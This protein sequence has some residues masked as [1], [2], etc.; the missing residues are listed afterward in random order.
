MSRVTD[1][2]YYKTVRSS[3]S[4][5]KLRVVVFHSSSLWRR[6][7]ITFFVH[8]RIN[9]ILKSGCG[10]VVCILLMFLLF[11][12]TSRIKRWSLPLFFPHTTVPGNFPTHHIRISDI[13][14]LLPY[15]RHR[16]TWQWW[17]VTRPF[18]CA[19]LGET[20]PRMWP[21]PLP[22]EPCCRTGQA[23]PTWPCQT[24]P[25]TRRERTAA[26]QLTGWAHSQCILTL[27]F[28]V[29]NRAYTWA[30]PWAWNYTA[31]WYPSTA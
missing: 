22:T 2:L 29:S 23:T 17:K 21:G 24:R 7:F 14:T 25:V 15:W 1:P 4:R 30:L 5:C 10:S 6:F 26:P 20:P 27:L 3:L 16:E 12:V 13:Q 8:M 11:W 19:L 31:T 28:G 18:W 9:N